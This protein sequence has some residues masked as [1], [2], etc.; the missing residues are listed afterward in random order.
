MADKVIQRG[1]ATTD[2][3]GIRTSGQSSLMK[4]P[5]YRDVDALPKFREGSSNPSK[6]NKNVTG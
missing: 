2:S 3:G 6:G 1:K 5:V 4:G